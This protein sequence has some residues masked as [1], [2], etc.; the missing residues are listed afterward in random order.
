MLTLGPDSVCDICL[1]PFSSTKAASVITC[2]HSFCTD[3]IGR[4][5]YAPSTGAHADPS[6]K[7]CPLCRRVF[8]TRSHIRLH[9]DHDHT[10]AR[11]TSR[12]DPDAK[13]LLD[14][15]A[16]ILD[17]GSSEEESKKC[18]SDIKAF[19][20]S[21]P[22]DQFLEMDLCC[23]MLY[24]M[25]E[26]RT[27]NRQLQTRKTELEGQNKELEDQKR[28]LE[29]QKAECENL[30][31][32]ARK[33]K[34]D[35]ERKAHEEK[36]LSLSI[37]KSLS[38]YAKASRDGYE[39]MVKVG[40]IKPIFSQ[41][42]QVV[43]DLASICQEIEQGHYDDSSRRSSPRATRTAASRM[44]Q[45]LSAYHEEHIR[46]D[47]HI[48]T[49]HGNFFVT[50]VATP[51][52]LPNR[53]ST[54][55]EEEDSSPSSSTLPRRHSQ[56]SSS[57][58]KPATEP[59]VESHSNASR[60]RSSTISESEPRSVATH[61]QLARTVTMP[62]SDAG[63]DA[64][65]ERSA[66]TLVQTPTLER[67]VASHR[68][69]QGAEETA[70]TD[71]SSYT[72][73][74]PGLLAERLEQLQLEQSRDTSR[75]EVPADSFAPG[76]SS[77]STHTTYEPSPASMIPYDPSSAPLSSA[78]AAAKAKARERAE[79]AERDK[80]IE[81]SYPDDDAYAQNPSEPTSSSKTR[82]SSDYSDA[83]N[84]YSQQQGASS[85]RQGS[86]QDQQPTYVYASQRGKSR[87]YHDDGHG[88]KCIPVQYLSA[89]PA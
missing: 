39:T 21:K 55:Q 1:D 17:T 13:N 12:S 11:T 10:S 52:A 51:A 18:I 68:D 4:L 34:A 54:P 44:S 60:L 8:D 15:L 19:V 41:Y 31:N 25:C 47:S 23:R 76:P 81:A 5:R 35:V 49:E 82:R 9:I 22:K 88:N 48:L 16:K 57:R 29:N 53:P 63:Y 3:C 58:Y 87:R 27:K 79:K 26:V 42:N 69:S 33:E 32:R 72:L 6:Y 74:Q 56:S 89:T 66:A 30:L 83:Y 28:E 75:N 46:L 67:P 86:S 2:G 45:R 40:L 20:R 7:P 85:S 80:R 77:R 70:D 84:N 62:D 64:R 73:P 37:E 36:E 71:V 65:S 43:N 50:P 59:S 61:R 38:E 78:S 24:Y 14:R